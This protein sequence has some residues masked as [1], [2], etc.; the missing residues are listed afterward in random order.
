VH[1]LTCVAIAAVMASLGLYGTMMGLLAFSI[2]VRRR[3][4][5]AAP[6]VA[7]R[8]TI[9]KPLAGADDD[10]TGNLE[11]F[12]AIDYPSFEILFGVASPSD[13]AMRCAREFLARHPKLD[14]RILVT[15][16]ED[17]TN[18]K[19]AQLMTLERASTGDVCVIS[20]SNVRVD[21]D[22]LWPLVAEL[23][24]PSVGIVTSL[25]AGTGERTLGAAL[26]NLQLCAST[27]PGILAMDTVSRRPLTVG[28]SMA[29]RR[30]D[31]ASLGGFAP[32][33]SVLAE[34]YVL[35]RRY[36]E[37]GFAARTSLARVENRNVDCTIGRTLERHTRWLKMRRA[38]A[39]VSFVLEPLLSPVTIATLALLVGR[40]SSV[41]LLFA[42]ACAAE[43]A[44]ALTA[45]RLVRGHAVPY[46][47][48]PL[49]VAR[50]YVVFLCWLRACASRRIEWRGHP[51]LLRRGSVIVPLDAE[52][53]TVD[54][55]VRV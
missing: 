25:F 27:A 44:G 48:A 3:R 29:M 18:P 31:L 52:R 43:C 54:S 9:F 47:Y 53:Q 45:S 4:R 33:G 5:A 34:D 32:L 39:P 51:F 19:V 50:A 16:P 37:S 15:N 11:S 46:R 6:G 12:A 23:T 41:A 8:V 36:F 10:L 49:A 2:L 7:P 28:K 35:G 55:V 26:E 22:Y 13:P 40:D 38:I 14:A 20:D 30:R 17:A 24:D 42:I 1:V 21:R